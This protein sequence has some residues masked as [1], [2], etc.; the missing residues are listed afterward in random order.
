MALT[1]ERRKILDGII[2]DLLGTCQML[3]DVALAHGVGELSLEDVQYIEEDIFLCD[4]CGWWCE[5]CEQNVGI[6]GA[7]CDECYETE[8]EN[9]DDY[10]NDD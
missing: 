9:D 6:L 5:R 8:H 7:I 2:Q 3:E 4:C 10:E 1:V